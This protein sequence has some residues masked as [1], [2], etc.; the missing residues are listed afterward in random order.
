M[1][2]IPFFN[3]SPNSEPTQFPPHSP[4]TCH[5]SSSHSAYFAPEELVGGVR[6]PLLTGRGGFG[7]VEAPFLPFLNLGVMAQQHLGTVRPAIQ[8]LESG[9]FRMPSCRG[10]VL[11][12]ASSQHAR[13]EPRHSRPAPKRAA[14]CEHIAADGSSSS[15]ISSMRRWSIPIMAA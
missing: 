2:G 14:S 3:S 9:S 13:A 11:P 7:G 15:T 12:A 8:R 10:F 5:D 1:L 6:L 4:G